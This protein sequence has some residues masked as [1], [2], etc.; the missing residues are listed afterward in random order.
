VWQWHCEIIEVRVGSIK[1]KRAEYAVLSGRSANDTISLSSANDGIRLF[2][3]A[4]LID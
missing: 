4:L 2:C 3:E 1:G